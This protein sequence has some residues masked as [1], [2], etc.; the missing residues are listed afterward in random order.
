MYIRKIEITNI[1]STKHL[2]LSF[3]APAGWHVIIGDNGS[4]KTTLIRSVALALVGAEF[5]QGLRQKWADWISKSVGK[6][7]IRLWIENS[8]DDRHTG[9][10]APLKNQQIQN[11][12]VITRS[13]DEAKLTKVKPTDG[14]LPERFNWGSGEG[15]FSAAYGPFRRFQGGNTEWSK[16]YYAQPK[17]GAHLSAFGEDVALTEATEWLKQLNY[18]ALEGNQ[19]SHQVLDGVIKLVN[20]E[21]FLPHGVKLS[22]ISS[23]G[24]FFQ[25]AFNNEISVNQ[26]SDGYRSILSLTF[27]LLRQLTFTYRQEYV[28]HAIWQGDMKIPVTGVVLI[29][30]VDAH[31]HPSWQ[32]RIGSWFTK[33]FPN[34]QFIVATHSPLVCRAAKA[35]TI[36]RLG[37]PG[38][39]DSA[40]E[41]TGQAR[42]RLLM[43]N[44]LEAY[45]TDLFGEKVSISEEAQKELSEL[46]NLTAKI[47]TNNELTEDEKKK[48]ELLSSRHPTRS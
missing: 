11:I 28:F 31:L 2:E 18:K 45:G 24:V 36:W 39:D 4:G 7:E 37:V 30:E 8:E 46:A 13:D 21:D 43:G 6:A 15:W 40:E 42:E 35:G 12:L 23:E 17:L 20:S 33:Y 27:E 22:K 29:D 34:I 16:V 44:I 48:Y 10:S 38:E 26:L 9:R 47:V 14:P 5:A 1:K 32:A 25:D 41:I 19:E 3:P